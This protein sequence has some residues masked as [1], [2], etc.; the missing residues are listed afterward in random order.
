MRRHLRMAIYL[1]K[2]FCL[3]NKMFLMVLSEF[4][5]EYNNNILSVWIG[6]RRTVIKKKTSLFANYKKKP[7]KPQCE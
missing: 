3:R 6:Q 5:E 1:V 7:Q 4:A 2:L